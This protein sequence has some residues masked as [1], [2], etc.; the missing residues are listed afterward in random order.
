M[1][2]QSD[3][4]LMRIHNESGLTV[5]DGVPMVWAG[6]YAGAHWM[7]RVYG[8]DL[9]LAVCKLA[10]RNGWRS[11]FYG[12]GEG[13]AELVAAEMRRRFPGFIVAGTFAP[14]FRFLTPEEDADVVQRIN[15]SRADIIWVGL[16]TPKQE[17]WMADHVARFDRAVILL[18]VGAAFN[19]HAGLRR[20]APRWLRPL[21]LHWLYRL[22]QE[23]RRLW[24]R[25]LIN[26]PAFVVEILRNRPRLLS[27]E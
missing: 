1:E 12:G 13:V 10:A 4:E 16:S 23:P 21:G 7:R 14:P 15:S 6:R 26:N 8:P 3:P 27:S 5:P 24:R 25:Y 19:L 18:G 2:S 11:F 22:G 9:M 17:R 20:D